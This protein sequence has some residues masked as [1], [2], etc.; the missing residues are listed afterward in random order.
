MFGNNNCNQLGFGNT[1]PN[2]NC[3]GGLLT[4]NNDILKNFNISPQDVKSF[5]NGRHHSLIL[6]QGK[7]NF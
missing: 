7:N 4:F 3:K 5:S 6:I 2:L 1:N